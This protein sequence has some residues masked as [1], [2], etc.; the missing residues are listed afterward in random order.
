VFDDVIDIVVDVFYVG[1][2]ALALPVADVVVAEGQDVGVGQRLADGV[3]VSC[4][5]RCRFDRKLRCRFDRK[6]STFL[7]KRLITAEKGF[8]V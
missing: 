1:R 3:V 6:F 8:I 7:Q 5:K 4:R 2:N